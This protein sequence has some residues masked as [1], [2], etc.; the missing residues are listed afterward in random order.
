MAMAWLLHRGWRVEAHRFRM[1]HHDLD[2]VARRGRVVAFIEVKT[3]GNRRFG[4]GLESVGWKKRAV[5]TRLAELWRARFG[6]PED[7]YRFDVIVVEGKSPTPQITHI[8]DAWR[9]VEK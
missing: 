1:G 9:G 7:T 6:G 8:T 3:R 5:L 2:L 4:S